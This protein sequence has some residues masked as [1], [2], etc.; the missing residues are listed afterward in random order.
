V[1]SPAVSRKAVLGAGLIL[2][3]VPCGLAAHGFAQRYDLPVPLGLYIGGAAAAVAFSFVVVAFFIRGDR[4]ARH[5]PRLNLLSNPV[6]RFLAGP[7]VTGLLRSLSVGLLA[8]VITGGFVGPENPFENIAPTAIWVIWWVGFAYISGLLGDLWAVVNP[9]SAV[10]TLAERTW[11]AIFPVRRFGLSLPWPAWLGRWPAVLLFAWFVWAELIWP[12]SDNPSSLAEA[13]LI[14]SVLT[15]SGMLLFGRHNWLRNAEAFTVVFGLLARFAPTE[16]RVTEAAICAR[17][18]SKDCD[19]RDAG[20]INCAECFEMAALHQREWN[21]RP[22]AVGLLTDQPISASSMVFVLL[23][24]SSVTFDGM[25]ATPV[26]AK[27]ADWMIYSQSL[28]PLIIAL[29]D[30]S[31][32]AIAAVGTI[33]L[34]AFLLGFQILYLL[35]GALMRLSVPAADRAG[36]STRQVAGLFVLSLVPIALAYHLAHYLSYLAI[37]GQFMIPLISD[38]FGLGWDLFGTRLYLVD[39]S[40]VNARMVWY[41]SVIAIVTGHVIAVWLA[42]V[43]ALRTFSGNQ[44]AL[45]SQIPML[46]LMVGYTMLSLWI[47]AQP[48][49]ETG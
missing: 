40:V 47:L 23:M 9:W 39:I 21:L 7:W 28:R 46:L 26:W 38:P 15:W 30:I 16:I 8:L 12:A 34:V 17:C 13:A 29:Q 49:V 22:W 24:L 5:Y 44:A 33:A 43:M 6:G 27:V 48:V 25:L 19:G 2:T 4:L 18:D 11:R 37:V 32:N 10:Y 35:F 14:Y 3:F 41:T 45:R 42:H 20:C 1:R 36:I 31:G